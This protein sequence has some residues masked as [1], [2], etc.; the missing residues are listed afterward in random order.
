M[1]QVDRKS[2]FVMICLDIPKDTYRNLMAIYKYAKANG[3]NASLDVVAASCIDA[4]H[5]VLL[6]SE[7]GGINE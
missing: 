2:D 5:Q 3:I 4:V 1:K 7:S 6:G